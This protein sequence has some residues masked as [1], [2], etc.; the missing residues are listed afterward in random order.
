MMPIRCIKVNMTN[1]EPIALENTETKTKPYIT[2]T[3][4][5]DSDKPTK[6]IAACQTTTTNLDARQNGEELDNLPEHFRDAFKIAA[7]LSVQYVWIDSL[8]I[9]QAGDDGQDFNRQK[10]K[11]AQYYQHSLLTI[12]TTANDYLTQGILKDLKTVPWSDPPVRLPYRGIDLPDEA[13]GHFY[14]YKRKGRLIDD[15]WEN[16]RSAEVFNRAWILQEWILSKR[17]LWYTPEG[18]FFECHSIAPRTP[19]GEQIIKNTSKQELHY[20]FNL[21]QRLHWTNTSI[22]DFWYDAIE[23]NSTFDIGRLSD[24][25]PA[26]AGL[27]IEVANVIAAAAPG[28]RQHNETAIRRVIYIAGL[29]LQDI[30]R[31]LLWEVE[32]SAPDET[33]RAE[34]VPSWSWISYFAPVKFPKPGSNVRHAMVI[35]GLCLQERAERHE[36]HWDCAYNNVTDMPPEGLFDPGNNFACLHIEGVVLP[37]WI[38]GY[39]PWPKDIETVAFATCYG[40][41]PKAG[42]WRAIHANFD[43]DI[44]MGWASVERLMR[45]QDVCDDY[46]SKVLALH[47]STRYFTVGWQL[48]RSL[49]VLDLLF[50]K[51]KAGRDGVYERIGVGRVFEKSIVRRFRAAKKTNVQLI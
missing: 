50:I 21:K 10:S 27:G 15:Y 11:M 35:M 33:R 22:M 18:M 24:R 4:R 29:W 1:G 30:H 5:W 13:G 19:F 7:K 32:P 46:G 17:F 25:V 26:V 34:N 28:E 48:T 23:V 8:C 45:E 20:L 44:I 49:P 2:L 51:E 14:M 31:G 38:R 41:P 36:P 3:H 42:R 6:R 39:I 43:D 47:V 12:A 16:V 40:G 9:I 37:V